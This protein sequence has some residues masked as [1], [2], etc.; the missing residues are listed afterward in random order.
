MDPHTTLAPAIVMIPTAAQAAIFQG[1]HPWSSITNSFTTTAPQVSEAVLFPIKLAAVS[2][3]SADC[4][5]S[6]RLLLV[7]HGGGRGGGES[8]PLGMVSGGTAEW[9]GWWYFS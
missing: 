6:L 5:P 8:V 4:A 1:A 3:L 7:V 2:K 9:G